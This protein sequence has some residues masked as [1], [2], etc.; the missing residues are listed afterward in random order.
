MF[1]VRNQLIG[2]AEAWQV[3]CHVTHFQSCA[4]KPGSSPPALLRCLLVLTCSTSGFIHKHPLQQRFVVHFTQTLWETDQLC[5]FVSMILCQW[6]WVNVGHSKDLICN[7]CI[8]GMVKP[9]RCI[10]VWKT[11]LNRNMLML[12]Q[13]LLITS[14]GSQDGYLYINSIKKLL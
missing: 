13:F 1:F 8:K 5:D 6:F 9:Y 11:V 12:V 14:E 3:S 10:L 2:W 4:L 7:Y